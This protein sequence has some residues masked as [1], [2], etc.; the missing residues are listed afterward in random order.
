[1]SLRGFCH[2]NKTLEGS[3]EGESEGTER[4]VVR[5]IKTCKNAMVD[6]SEKI[7]SGIQ[8]T[9]N[10]RN[11]VKVRG[12]RRKRERERVTGGRERIQLKLAQFSHSPVIHMPGIY[13]IKSRKFLYSYRFCIR[14]L[15][16]P[17]CPA[18]PISYFSV[19]H[20]MLP[21]RF[22]GATECR[23]AAAIIVAGKEVIP[24]FEANYV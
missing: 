11:R 13:I 4:Q 2:P 5:V 3:S 21:A 16:Q 10:S 1:M 19:L 20:V 23:F 17:F 9:G 8:S 14:A 12:R 24:G 15:A 6:K 7:A 18:C 22:L